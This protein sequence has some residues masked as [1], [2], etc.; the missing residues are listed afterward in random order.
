MVKAGASRAS[1]LCPRR[2][3]SCTRRMK[4]FLIRHGEPVNK[5]VRLGRLDVP[6]S[7]NGKKQ[8]EEVGNKL[9]GKGIS[10][11]YSSPLLRSLQTARIISNIFNSKLLISDE[12]TARDAGVVEG[13]TEEE[14]LKEY[15]SRINYPGSETLEEVKER[16][17]RFLEK[18]DGNVA[19]VTHKKVIQ[20]MLS[21]ILE[22]KVEKGLAFKIDYAHFV[23][24]ERGKFWKI[25]RM[26]C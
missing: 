26:N 9:R 18:L 8:A 13:K 25:V 7:E 24:V 21:Y 23:E 10:V 12:L 5:K 3:E 11:I 15:G 22:T 16:A 14:I 4:L 2:F 1:G 20:M 19:I 6:L 17:S